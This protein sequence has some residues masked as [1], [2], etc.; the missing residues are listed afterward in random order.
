MV[1]QTPDEFRHEMEIALGYKIT[2][3]TRGA[4]ARGYDGMWALALAMHQAEG[5]LSRRLD[6]YQYGDEEYARV[7]G[8]GILGTD[9]AGMTV[10]NPTK[11]SLSIVL[12]II[13]Y[14]QI[15]AL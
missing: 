14:V 8:E 4:A 7:I 6:T 5:V 3:R 10:G 13:R 12:I 1:F 11:H 9:F 15:V 2:V